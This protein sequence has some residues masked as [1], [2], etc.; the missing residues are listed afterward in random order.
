M[1]WDASIC[2][3]IDRKSGRVADTVLHTTGSPLL[4]TLAWHRQ[5]LSKGQSTHQL[6]STYSAPGPRT[7]QAAGPGVGVTSFL[8]GFL[9]RV[10]GSTR[11]LGAFDLTLDRK[12]TRL[13]SSH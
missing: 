10:P 6:L 9:R 12:S 5:M 2:L 7:G 1:D 13:N 11:K 8:K 3:R 4:P